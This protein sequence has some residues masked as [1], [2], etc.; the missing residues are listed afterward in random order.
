MS[1]KK[2]AILGI[3]AVVM[4]MWAVSQGRI[5]KEAGM[6]LRTPAYLIQGLDPADI[7]SIVL[8]TGE[9]AVTLKRRQKRFVVVDKGNYPAVTSKINDLIAKCLDITTAE[10]YTDDPANHKDLGVAEENAQ[11]VITFLKPDSTVLTGAV[12]GKAKEQGRGIFVRRVS[13]DDV[14]VTVARPAINDEIM[15]FIETKLVSVNEQEIESVTVSGADGYTITKDDSGDGIVLK[16]LP[17]GK[18]LKDSVAKNVFTALTNLSF[19]DV[20]KAATVKDALDFETQYICRLKDSTIYRIKVAQ[21]DDETFVKCKANFTDASPVT[22]KEVKDA[23][24]V[25]LKKKEAKLIAH[26]KANEFTSRHSNWIYKIAKVNADNLTRPL[27]ELIE[28]EQGNDP[29]ILAVQPDQ[30]K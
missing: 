28:D 20:Q 16:E 15:N 9:R 13:S 2:L 8:G 30:K 11:N 21:K 26:E 22:L 5:G 3:V 14:Y 18:K 4:V 6:K 1:N 19:E 10:L 27:S 7:G 29:N 17:A 23:N 12:I 24:E 25:E